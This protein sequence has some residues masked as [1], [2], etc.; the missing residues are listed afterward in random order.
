[1]RT[2][3][4]HLTQEEFEKLAQDLYKKGCKANALEEA[5]GYFTLWGLNFPFVDI[6][7]RDPKDQ[8]LM[9]VYKRTNEDNAAAYVMGAV[10]NP[11]SKKYSFHS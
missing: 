3:N 4:I 7:L 10:F 2:V 5:I 9:A 11:V 6:Y 1:M 8:E